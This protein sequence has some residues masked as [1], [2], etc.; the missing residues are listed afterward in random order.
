MRCGNARELFNRRSD[1]DTLTNWKEALALWRHCLGCA[2][3]R[4]ADRQFKHLRRLTRSLPR[5]LPSSSVRVNVLAALPSMPL[6]PS[7]RTQKEQTMRNL[8]IATVATTLILAVA[9][10]TWP[11]SQPPVSAAAKVRQSLA[12]VNTWH[13][14]GWK[15]LDSQQFAWE[16]WGQ[17]KPF[18]YRERIGDE[19]VLDDGRQ[20]VRVLD[21]A[22]NLNRSQGIVLRTPSQPGL[23]IVGEGFTHSF[24]DSLPTRPIQEETAEEIV[25]GSQN[26]MDSRQ[27][28]DIYTISKR[29]W[30]PVRYDVRVGADSAVVE[31]LDALYDHALPM[32]LR[33]LEWPANYLVVDAGSVPDNTEV[34]KDNVARY[35]GLTVQL[36]PLAMDS[37]GRILARVRGWLGSVRIAGGP[38]FMH[39]IPKHPEIEPETALHSI[40]DDEGHPYLFVP[41]EGLR[42]IPDMKPG[43]ERLV[44]FA[45]FKPLPANTLPRQLKVTLHVA[46]FTSIMMSGRGNDGS[47]QQCILMSTD[48]TWNLALPT[49]PMQLDPDAYLYKGWRELFKTTGQDV[50]PLDVSV[51]QARTEMLRHLSSPDKL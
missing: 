7:I 33:H 35:G 20:R 46:P 37:Q 5:H 48:L 21:A 1:G 40:S 50:P 23:N 25:F 28:H 3:C 51:A 34:P 26:D 2:Q 32:A 41:V 4:A 49:R 13:L 12:Q 47:V 15:L 8:R 44:Y 19:T 10:M 18:F 30:L 43:T 45:P 24:K 27:K 38:F 31:H 39:V 6:K 9:L 22:P 11:R 16:V 42:L 17:R 14:R 36:T 29:T